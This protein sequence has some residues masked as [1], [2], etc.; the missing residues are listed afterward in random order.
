[1]LNKHTPS[2]SNAKVTVSV[3]AAAAAMPIPIN[4]SGCLI[5][6]SSLR[7]HYQQRWS[8]QWHQ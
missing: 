8:Y 3:A 4:T 2:K 5:T 7:S 1:M 6:E